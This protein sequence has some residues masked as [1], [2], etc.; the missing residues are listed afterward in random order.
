Y[1]IQ[2]IRDTDKA[3]KVYS[4]YR[5]PKTNK[6]LRK[7]SE[8]VA[9]NSYHLK[10]QAIDINLPGTDLKNL[11]KLATFLRR[12]GVGYY[13]RSGFMHIDTGPIRYW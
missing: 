7:N 6:R 8:G 11:K 1:S 5:S 2:L 4:G 13:P 12:G 3:I 10:A 9:K